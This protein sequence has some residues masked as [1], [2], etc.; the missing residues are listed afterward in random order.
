M[1][2]TVTTLAIFGLLAVSSAFAQN[3]DVNRISFGLKG[4]YNY[5]LLSDRTQLSTGINPSFGA[6][7]EVTANP[8]WGAGLEY[9]YLGNNQDAK[10][11]GENLKSSVNALTYYNSINITNLVSA[12]RSRGWQKFNVFG[13]LGAGIGIYSYDAGAGKENGVQ[14]SVMGALSA[15]YNFAKWF[16]LGVESQYRANPDVKFIPNS[17]TGTANQCGFN[18]TARFKLG[19][20]KENVRN[21][22]LNDYSPNPCAQAVAQN[23]AALGQESQQLS[24]LQSTVASQDQSIQA[25]QSQV[26]SLQSQLQQQAAARQAAQ[27]AQAQAAAMAAARPAPKNPNTQYSNIDFAV[28]DASVPTSGYA[29]LDQLAAELKANPT[30]KVQVVGYTDNTGTAAINNKLSKDRADA[31]KSYLVSKGVADSAV[32]TQGLGSADPIA[33]NDTEQGRAQNRRIE[34]TWIK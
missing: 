25:L 18:V 21:V 16:A 23:T 3:N 1:K 14:P 28:D 19:R 24:T 10:S 29:E 26:Q 33:S 27:A 15:E 17:Y 6:F 34:I 2:K 22:A 4:G 8:L 30:W 13:T 11:G 9:L 7:F 5:L 20:D 32:S 31:I 12:N